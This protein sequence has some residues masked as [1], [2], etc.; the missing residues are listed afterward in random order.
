VLTNGEGIG[1]L[2]ID[3]LLELGGVPASIG[4]IVRAKLDAVLPSTWSG[5]NPVD[6][7]GDADAARYAAAL[8]AL[9]SDRDNDAVLVLNVQTAIAAADEVAASV[10]KLVTGYREQ[11]RRWAK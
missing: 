11:H 5:S 8:E 3:R 4:P 7:V 6:I 10:A 9:L 1:N 2:A